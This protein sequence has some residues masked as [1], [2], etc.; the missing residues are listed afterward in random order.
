MSLSLL[1]ILCRWLHFTALILLVGAV[2]YTALLAPKSFRSHLILRLHPLIQGT[3]VLTLFSAGALLAVQTGLMSGDWHDI[4]DSETWLAVLGT[5][6]G[7]AWQWQIFLSAAACL[8]FLYLRVKRQLVLFVLGLVQLCGLAFVGHAT[9]LEGWAGALQRSNH[10][11]HLISAAFWAGGLLPLLLLMQEVS[12]I[13]LRDDAIRTMMRFSRYGHL[14]VALAIIT[15]MVN[16]IMILGWPL[17]SFAAYSQWLALKICLV[18]VMIM[19]ALFNRYWLVPRFQLV[20]GEAHQR[21]ILMTKIELVIAIAVVFV[22]SV[23]ATLP[24]A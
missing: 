13:T 1:F 12:K 2:S 5:R 22:V 19:I 11:I 15:G 16:S 20:G 10:A 23:Y 18:A 24:P 21:F 17:S 8:V 4:G 14:A 3:C 7:Q 6:F 9:M